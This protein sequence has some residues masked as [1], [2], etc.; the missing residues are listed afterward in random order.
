[1][2]ICKCFFFAIII[3]V[4][5]GCMARPGIKGFYNST[6][7]KKQRL[8]ILNRDNYICTEP[9]CSRMG[10]EVHH[11]IELNESN[12]ND[13]NICLNENNLRTLC[14]ECHT[15]ITKEMKASNENVLTKIVFDAQGFP[16]EIPG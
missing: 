8:Y 16:V 5:G 14:H 7:W 2:I 6:L 1:M 3:P 12:V 10:T 11:I 9:G 15:R 13:Y 4:G